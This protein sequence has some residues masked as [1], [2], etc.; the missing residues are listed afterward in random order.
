MIRKLFHVKIE[1]CYDFIV[2]NVKMFWKI[3]SI[4]SGQ[5]GKAGQDFCLTRTNRSSGSRV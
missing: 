3:T 2:F 1:A 5:A 4:G